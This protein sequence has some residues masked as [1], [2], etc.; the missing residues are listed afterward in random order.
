ML[1]IPLLLIQPSLWSHT[2]N[3]WSPKRVLESHL[4]ILESRRV[5]ENSMGP[6][7]GSSW[8]C[9]TWKG[10]QDISHLPTPPHFPIVSTVWKNK[11]TRPTPSWGITSASIV[12]FFSG[13]SC[14]PYKVPGPFHSIFP[15]PER[16]W[17]CR[18]STQRLCQPYASQAPL[19][20]ASYLSLAAL[21]LDTT[22]KHWS[23]SCLRQTPYKCNP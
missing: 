2:H 9:T 10:Y 18:T 14:D 6:Q 19:S 20:W 16:V 7:G 11:G 22:R 13:P 3:S 1:S 5:W 4:Q 21:S 12:V 15:E 17:N 23:H 8:P